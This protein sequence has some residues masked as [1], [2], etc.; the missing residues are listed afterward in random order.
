MS[1]AGGDEPDLATR[2]RRKIRRLDRWQQRHQVAAFP[3]AV[4][5]K[6]SDDRASAQA[7]IIA[8][9]GFF[10]LF[11]LLLLITSVS[12]FLLEDDPELQERVLDVVLDQFP[13]Q[14][15]QLRDAIGSLA[16]SGLTLAVGLV[17]TAYVALR[18]LWTTQWISDQL[19]GVPHV[20]R[21]NVLLGQLRSLLVVG[22]LGVAVLANIG[23]NAAG[24]FVDGYPLLVDLG[25]AI[26]SFAL[27]TATF[28]L[29]FHA[30][31]DRP[32]AWGD[33]WP[34]AVTAAVGWLLLLRVGTLLLGRSF[35]SLSPTS[36]FVVTLGLLAWILLQSRIVLLATEVNVVRAERL[37][38]RSLTRDPLTE[39]D[40]R[41]LALYAQTQERVEGELVSVEFVP[42]GERRTTWR[43]SR[44]LR[45]AD[46]RRRRGQRPD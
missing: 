26:A 11:P 27:L 44:R 7:A 15:D 30:L 40:R 19:W 39:A 38:P 18:T 2:T 21:P 29:V 37:W 22:V 42:P 23:L 43:E 32:L 5:R 4:G 24:T 12:G 35:R 6:W 33:L 31:T 45:R 41:A 9:Y 28:A 46:R 1:R 25:G 3:V 17:G 10:S 36:V 34:G 14:A 8:F 20:R 16:G 13:D